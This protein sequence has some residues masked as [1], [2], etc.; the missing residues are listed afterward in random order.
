[1]EFCGEGRDEME[2]KLVDRD[3]LVRELMVREKKVKKRGKRMQFK[4]R[5]KKGMKGLVPG[6]RDMKKRKKIERKIE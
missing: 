4:R 2:M 3:F 5:K 1:M 6:K